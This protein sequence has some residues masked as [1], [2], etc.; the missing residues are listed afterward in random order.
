MAAVA[1]TEASAVALRFKDKALMINFM[2]L[3]L[4]LFKP[5]CPSGEPYYEYS[6]D[7]RIG[8]GC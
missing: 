4:R 5:I 8:I 3:E 7:T 1:S 6:R 2:E